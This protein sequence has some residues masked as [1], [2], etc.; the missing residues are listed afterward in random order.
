MKHILVGVSAIVGM[1]LWFLLVRLAQKQKGNMI[2]DSPLLQARKTSPSERN[3]HDK[4][5]D[6]RTTIVALPEID[7]PSQRIQAHDQLVTGPKNNTSYARAYESWPEDLPFPCY[8]AEFF[9]RRPLLGHLMIVK[10]SDDGAG[11]FFQRPLKTG[12]TT[13]AGTVMRIAHRKKHLVQGGGTTIACKHRSNHGTAHTHFRYQDRDKK[14]SFLF[15]IIRDPTKRAI[16][17]FFH[18]SVSVAQKD[19]TDLIFQNEMMSFSYGHY[20]LRDLGFRNISHPETA[21]LK[22]IVKEIIDGYNFIAITERIDESL[23]VLKMLLGLDLEDI[24]YVRERSQGAFSN[25]PPLTR[26][27]LYV[28]PSFLTTGMK[29]FFASDKWKNHMKGDFMLYEAA[30]KSLDLTIDR[31]GRD[32]VEEELARFKIAL[33]TAQDVCGPRAISMCREDGSKATNT[34]CYIWGEGCSHD[35]LDEIKVPDSL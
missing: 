32:K 31:L 18:F 10:P 9:A 1:M 17:Q 28:W 8:P 14:K 5:S 16:S 23:V 19:P 12:S 3:K 27:C 30:K 26:P 33:N 22:K 21:N 4:H 6:T 29:A 35:C 34:T 11:L 24:L 20:Y 2:R 15:S 7:A 13:V 25:G